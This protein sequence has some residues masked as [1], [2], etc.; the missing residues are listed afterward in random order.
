[1]LQVDFVCVA[2]FGTRRTASHQHTDIQ[3]TTKRV[4]KN[5]LRLRNAA[6]Y[7]SERGH[8]EFLVLLKLLFVFSGIV[9]AWND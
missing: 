1:M 6:H 2:M 3:D 9:F 7:V 5:A 8:L 4:C